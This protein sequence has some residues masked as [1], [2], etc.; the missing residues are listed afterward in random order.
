MKMNEVS[1][2]NSC[3]ICG[4]ENP[5]GLQT[6]P[7]LDRTARRATLELTIPKRFQGWR[8]LAHGGILAALLDEVSVYA[9]MS[10]STQ[11]VTAGIN[12]RYL[13]P[14]PV[15]QPVTVTAEVVEIKRRKLTVQAKLLYADELCAEAEATVM[16]LKRSL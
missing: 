16:E 12:V 4:M 11:F 10:D 8:G 7:T 13:K 9:C 5:T 15:E 6:K 2:D 1:N 14:V 3:F